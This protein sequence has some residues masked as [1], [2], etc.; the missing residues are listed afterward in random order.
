MI[1]VRR[2]DLK[3]IEKKERICRQLDFTISKDQSGKMKE[4]GKIVNDLDIAKNL[5]NPWTWYCWYH[6]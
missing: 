6:L 4:S 3:L 1:L 5:K 2:Q